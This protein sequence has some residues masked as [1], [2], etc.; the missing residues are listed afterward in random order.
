MDELDRLIRERFVSIPDAEKKGLPR[1]VA[2]VYVSSKTKHNIRPFCSLLYHTAC[3]VRT[4]GRK[5]KLLAK[6]VPASYVAFE[7]VVVNLTDELR[8]KQAEPVLKLNDFWALT[9][10]RMAEEYGRPFRDTFEFR[11]ACDFLHENGKRLNYTH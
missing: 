6:T 9:N 5:Q 3:E 1:V 8:A 11:Q 7:K 10:N 4:F 2:S